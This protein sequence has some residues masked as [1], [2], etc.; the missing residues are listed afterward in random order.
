L[1]GDE[2]ARASMRGELQIVARKLAGPQDPLEV[3]ASTVE[4]YLKE[5]MVH[6]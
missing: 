5:E 3:A 6:A 2:S 1:L 4:K